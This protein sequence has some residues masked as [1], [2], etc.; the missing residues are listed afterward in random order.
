MLKF[1]ISLVL[2]AF[3]TPTF[4]MES[5]L[6]KNEEEGDHINFSES[7]FLNG[8][9]NSV[10]VILLDILVIDDN[11]I[12]LVIME[13]MLR[14]LGCRDV[15]LVESAEVAIELIKDKAE[16]NTYFGMVFTDIN[17]PGMDGI[18]CT[19]EIRKIPYM[20][21]VPIIAV[22]TEEEIEERCLASGINDFMPKPFTK[23]RLSQ[24]LT[25]A[26]LNQ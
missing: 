21:S 1:L 14:E 3:F 8:E 26:L 20:K 23:I 12:N 10:P 15:T 11:K 19:R 2:A 13:R 25:K 6:E 18:D 5:S 9:P 24:V 22:T 16:K 7:P 4:A 17:M